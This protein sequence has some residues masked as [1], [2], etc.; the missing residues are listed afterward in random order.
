MMHGLLGCRSLRLFEMR[1]D[2]NFVQLFCSCLWD[3]GWCVREW[4]CCWFC[5]MMIP[6]WLEERVLGPWR[7]FWLE[8]R[9][10]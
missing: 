8:E 6:R 7:S 10:M 5:A 9:G 2:Q 1:I 3:M 4:Q